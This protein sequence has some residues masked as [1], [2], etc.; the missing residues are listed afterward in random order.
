M[1]SG[2]ITFSASEAGGL[3]TAQVHILMRAHDPLS[4]L[5]LT[6]GGHR[7]EDRF[8]QKTLEALASHLGAEGEVEKEVVCVDRRRQWSRAAN[9]WQSSAIRSGTYAA[10][11]PARALM[12]SLRRVSA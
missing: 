2:W 9:V 3:T 11:A 6:F 5:G 4:E 1:F 12:R 10:T 8:W 7:L